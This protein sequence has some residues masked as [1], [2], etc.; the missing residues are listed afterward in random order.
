MT[1]YRRF[2]YP[3]ATW[4]FTVNLAERHGN[5]LLTDKIDLLRMAFTQVKGRHVFEI[6]AMVVLPEHLHC[7]LTLPA[8]DSDFSTRWG[9]IKAYFSRQVDRG[10]RISKS[11]EKRGERGIWQRRFWEH[12]I[13]DEVD[14]RQHVD[15]IHWNPVKRGWVQSVKDWP[16]SSFH[17]YVKMGV[18]PE[19]WGDEIDLSK[20]VA[21]E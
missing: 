3:G 12:L 15:Y 9:L 6:D 14:Y 13:R 10:E 4:F 20:I 21:R 16:H 5:R 11:R 17:R 8:G 2:Q 1:N 19:N 7:I 18:Y